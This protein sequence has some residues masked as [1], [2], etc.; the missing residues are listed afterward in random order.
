MQTDVPLKVLT[1][2]CPEDLLALIGSPDATVLE[3]VSLELPASVGRLDNVLYLRSAAGTEYRHLVEWQGYRDPLFLPRS[4]G[5]LSW[6]AVHQPDFPLA[7]TLVYLRREDDAGSTLRQVLDGRVLWEVELPCVRLWEQDATA[8]VASGR[9]GLLVLSPLMGG[10]TAA[11][12]EEA[13]RA[14]LAQTEPSRQRADLLSILGVF[15]EPLL[16]AIRF[17]QLMGR[18]QLMASELMDL[19]VGYKIAE[20]DA[21]FA[22]MVAERDAEL[23][24]VVAERD[25]ELAELAVDALAARFPSAP[26]SLADLIRQV[27][28]PEALKQLH[29]AVLHAPDQAAA[30]LVIRDAAAAPANPR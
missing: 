17:L 2:T 3:V 23:A 13:G 12:V 5:Y 15:A 10:A 24:E 30:E 9:L 25:A 29:R 28:G 1:S 18:E 11:L 19:L 20:M 22:E 21:K 27:R 26:I 6:L 14:V 8:A 7:V 4:L 16:D